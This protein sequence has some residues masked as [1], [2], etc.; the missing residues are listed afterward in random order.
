MGLTPRG[1]ETD[2][3]ATGEVKV[4]IPLFGGMVEK[5]VVDAVIKGLDQELVSADAWLAE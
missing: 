1:D 3:L 5:V 2:F 4:S